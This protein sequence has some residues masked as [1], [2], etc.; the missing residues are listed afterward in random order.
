MIIDKNTLSKLADLAR[1]EIEP[2]KEVKL[3]GD[4][5]NILT[6]FEELKKVNTKD[7]APMAGGTTL[8]NSFRDDADPLRLDNKSALSAFPDEEKGFLR[9]PPVFSE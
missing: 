2:K 7:M 8:T 9:V 6:H 1:I 4:L 3:L 5:E